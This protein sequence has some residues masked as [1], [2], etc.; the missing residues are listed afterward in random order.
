MSSFSPWL[1]FGPKSIGL[2]G[3]GDF[4]FRE[5]VVVIIKR[6]WN[7]NPVLMLYELK[8]K[9]LHIKT[10][11]RQSIMHTPPILTHPLKSRCFLYDY[12]FE[13]HF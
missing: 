9:M 1:S 4:A 6:Y 7:S 11:Q 2:Y 3:A 10:F 5:L 12:K 13:A 8:K